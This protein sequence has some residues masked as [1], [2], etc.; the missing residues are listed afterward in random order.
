MALK[1]IRKVVA[2]WP[3]Q[4]RFAFRW[5]AWLICLIG[6]G[7]ATSAWAAIMADISL[8]QKKRIDQGLVLSSEFHSVEEIDDQNGLE[9]VT[10]DG[11]I[12]Q[13]T[14][15]FDQNEKDYGPSNKVRLSGQVLDAKRQIIFAFAP[16]PIV[17]ALGERK[18]FTYQDKKN[19]Q[20]IELSIRPAFH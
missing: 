1:S 9:A 16:Q 14:C 2:C 13:I 20:L 6:L 4:N 7:S 11:T 3:L 10:N 15:V 12:I 18:T 8:A 5:L 19:G 17:M